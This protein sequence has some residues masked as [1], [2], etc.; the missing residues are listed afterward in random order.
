MRVLHVN[1]FDTGGAAIA[2][3]RLHKSL[4]DQGV[5]S[6]LVTLYKSRNDIPFHYQ[7]P[8]RALSVPPVRFW[9]RIINRL[10]GIE[11]NPNKIW[12]T[13][14]QSQLAFKKD[15][16]ENF[17]YFSFNETP[18]RL[19]EWSLF[20]EFDVINLHWVADFINWPTFFSKTNNKKIV[21]TLHDFAPFTGGYHY[22]NGYNGYESGEE[23]PPFL[24]DS[25]YANFVSQ[26]LTQKIQ[27]FKENNV[28]IKIVVLSNWLK[29]CSLKSTLF[30]NFQHYLI[31]NSLDLEVYR[32]IEKNVARDILRLNKDSK[33]LLFVSETVKN[34]RKG[35]DILQ[36][37]ISNVDWS[38][39]NIQVVTIGNVHE[40]NTDS[41]HVKNFGPIKD[42]ILLSLLYSSADCFIMPSRE[43]NLPNVMLESLACGTP[44]VAFSNG[45][46]LDVIQDDVNGKLVMEQTPETLAAAIFNVLENSDNYNSQNIRSYIALNFN[47]RLQVERY[48]SIYN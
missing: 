7:F 14:K 41:H 47:D 11:T 37:A 25:R 33:I 1:T 30:K 46:M 21:W 35:F 38:K 32:P 10:R 15:L 43:D 36:K 8:Q 13:V 34:H 24:N 20:G 6:S 16:S 40:L 3:I 5:D 12:D 42:E 9:N 23:N 45:G 4:L 29:Q 18:H 44:V 26:Q 31:P 48:L 17:E 22:P 27:I 28:E 2:A 19:E 39:W